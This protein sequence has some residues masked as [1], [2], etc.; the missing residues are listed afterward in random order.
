V[1]PSNL[2][3]LIMAVG[4]IENT[5]EILS[6]ADV[7]PLSGTNEHCINSAMFIAVVS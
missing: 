3:G 7:Q 1:K 4:R 5:K 6:L 2:T